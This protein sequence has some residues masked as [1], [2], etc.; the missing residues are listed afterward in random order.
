MSEP[1]EAFYLPLGDGRYE[2]T[3]ATES[4]WDPQAQHGG[5]PTAL[6]GHLL[7]AA[8]GP[9]MRLA[10]ISADFL[11][12]IP[13]RPFRVEVAELRP[14]RRIALFE[15][16]MVVDGRPAVV[17]RAWAI[18]TGPT[19]PS[20]GRRIEPPALPGPGQELDLSGWGYGEAV[21]WRF[22][23]GGNDAS[24]SADVWTRVRIPLVAGEKL[25]GLARTLVVAD[26]AN[27]LSAALPIEEWLFIPP[28]ITVTLAR[29]PA[30]EWVHLACRSHLS[31]DGIGVSHA[32]LC[33]PDG[34]LG[35]VSQPLLVRPR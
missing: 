5:P 6:L 27:G 34:H 9:G 7:D 29:F 19:P 25:T 8:A 10:R 33:D 31:A 22:T 35:E 12:A 11:G 18:G 13:R 17:A 20:S 30:A 3:R 24:G 15:A 28:S 16:R 21:E 26:S 2:P 1:A 32:T 14:G 23:G 4:P